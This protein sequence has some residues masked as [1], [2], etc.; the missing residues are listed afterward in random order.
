MNAGYL[1]FRVTDGDQSSRRCDLGVVWLRVPEGGSDCYGGGDDDR[2]T[3]LEKARFRRGPRV[4]CCNKIQ[5]CCYSVFSSLDGCETLLDFCGH[6]EADRQTRGSAEAS[7]GPSHQP[8]A[9]R[10]RA[11]TNVPCENGDTWICNLAFPLLEDAKDSYV[12]VNFAPPLPPSRPW[13]LPPP[14][15]LSLSN[16]RLNPVLSSSPLCCGGDVLWWPSPSESPSPCVRQVTAATLTHQS[17]LGLA[18]GAAVTLPGIQPSPASRLVPNTLRSS[19][20]VQGTIVSAGTMNILSSL[21]QTGVGIVSDSTQLLSEDS[22]H[23]PLLVPTPSPQDLSSNSSVPAAASPS[24]SPPPPRHTPAQQRVTGHDQPPHTR[25]A[26]PGL[27]T[28]KTRAVRRD[29]ESDAARDCASS[30]SARKTT[31]G[32]TC[33]RP[34]YFLKSIV[35]LLALLAAATTAYELKREYNDF[36]HT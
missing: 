19:S 3:V 36:K 2:R 17:Y 34:K 20:V 1:V 5:C 33:Y 32:K 7:L 29:E 25:W 28:P 12:D 35:S 6:V 16:P 30:V 10:R 15:S 31:R 23:S 11:L 27:H 9:C 4:L 24:P 22:T 8:Q 18:V 26:S 14:A 21:T 13:S